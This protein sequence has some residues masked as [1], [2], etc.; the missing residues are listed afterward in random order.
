M[1]FQLIRAES[2]EDVRKGG[3]GIEKV[4]VAVAQTQGLAICKVVVDLDRWIVS[5]LLAMWW[6]RICCPRC[7][8][9]TETRYDR[10]MRENLL[11]RGIKGEAE[12]RCSRPSG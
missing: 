6:E 10:I 7:R 1:R 3:V 8:W 9:P 11:H 5:T 4:V 2:R 12:L